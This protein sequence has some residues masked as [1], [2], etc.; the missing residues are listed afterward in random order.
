MCWRCVEE[1]T[2][3]KTDP[4]VS[5]I[6]SPTT[7][8]P[9]QL[10]SAIPILA[11]EENVRG[12]VAIARDGQQASVLSV[13]YSLQYVPLC[14]HLPRQHEARAWCSSG[15]GVHSCCAI[16]NMKPNLQLA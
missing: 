9:V 14:W 8:M 16:Q 10:R 3:G 15:S 7:V 4:P 13:K 11:A 1:R 12:A 5:T 2:F 6:A